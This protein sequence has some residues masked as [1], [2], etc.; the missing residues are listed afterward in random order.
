MEDRDHQANEKTPRPGA[1]MAWRLERVTQHIEANIHGKLALAE[2]AQVACLSPFHFA[3]AFK[4]ATGDT[5]HSFVVGRRIAA[6]KAMLKQSDISLLEVA[7][8]CGFKTQSHFTGVFRKRVGLT[9]NVYRG[10]RVVQAPRH[11]GI[12]EEQRA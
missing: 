7:K 1:L 4:A 10:E 6:A 12:A 11:A 3:R 5:P 9:P 8:R 2:L